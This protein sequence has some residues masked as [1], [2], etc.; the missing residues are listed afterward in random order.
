MSATM[1]AWMLAGGILASLALTIFGLFT[2]FTWLVFRKGEPVWSFL[3]SVLG[4]VKQAVSSN[5]DVRSLVDKRPALS[6]FLTRRFSREDI[7]GW[8]TTLLFMAFLYVFLLFMRSEE[9][10]SELQS[11]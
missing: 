1:S 2:L 10:T 8:P 3:G 11:H 4:S 7:Y 9:H 5:P 6:R